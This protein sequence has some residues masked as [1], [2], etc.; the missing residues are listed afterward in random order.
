M[1]DAPGGCLQ[2]ALTDLEGDGLVEVLVPGAV[3]DGKTG[4]LR[5]TLSDA[6]TPLIAADLNGNRLL[7]IGRPACGVGGR[8]H[9]H[10]RR[11]RGRQFSGWFIYQNASLVTTSPLQG[12]YTG[13]GR[14]PAA[15]GGGEQQAAIDGAACSHVR[16]P[17]AIRITQSVL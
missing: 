14:D 8:R 13:Q 15:G 9:A 7:E 2:P 16:R 10:E 1:A 3:L 6:T 12:K 11:L 5:M 17:V 4:A